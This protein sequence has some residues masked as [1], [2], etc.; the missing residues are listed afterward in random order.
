MRSP[1]TLALGA[2]FLLT[3]GADAAAA[4]RAKQVAAPASDVRAGLFDLPDLEATSTRSRVAWVDVQPGERVE[5]AVD[6]AGPLSIAA[7]A[8]DAASWRTSVR[9]PDGA[10]RELAREA[11]EGRAVRTSAALDGFFAG[12]EA[13]R[14]DLVA[15]AAGVWDARVQADADGALIVRTAGAWTLASHRTTHATLSDG[16]IGFA[17]RLEGPDGEPASLAGTRGELTAYLDR[18]ELTLP[19]TADGELF[20]A[21]LPPGLRGD[22]RV[23]IDL[24]ATTPAGAPLHRTTWH[25]FRVVDRQAVLTGAAHGRAVGDA[26]IEISLGARRAG[27]AERA[28]VSAE[29]WG[30]NAAGELEPMC[31]LSRMAPVEGTGSH[32]RV[33]M[34]L[35]AGWLDATGLGAPFELRE[36]RLQDPDTHA[37]FDAWARIPLPVTSLPRTAGRSDGAITREMLTGLGPDVVGTGGAGATNEAGSG[38]YPR[39]LLLTHGYCSGGMPFTSSHFTGPKAVFVDPDQNRTHDEF[40]LLLQAFGADFRTFGVVGHSQGGSAALHLLTYYES[41]LDHAVGPRRIQSVGTP[42]QGTPLASLGAFAC[43]VNDDMTPSGAATWLAGI[44]SWARAEV[45][46]WT[47]SNSGSACQFLTSLFLTDPEDGTTEQSRGQLPGGNNR[48]H[49]VG[50]CHT[51]GMSD[52]PQATDLVRN[53]ERNAEAA[54]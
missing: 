11:S 20:T 31:W 14:V 21:S 9:G 7:L 5:L 6:A 36:A 17:A 22:V 50:W 26:R 42:Y 34:W 10:W 25:A 41:G 45:H 48:G 54:R 49:L 18:G 8:P 38:L 23:R 33:R 47:T 39:A 44:P 52:P 30:T 28:H 3:L 35:H 24:R 19:M 32:A 27:P 4:Q 15:H 12:H 40:A 2:T 1:L 13:D 53:I 37:P 43:G 46:Y 51:T 29:V 16:P